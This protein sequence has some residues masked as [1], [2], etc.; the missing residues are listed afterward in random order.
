MI[1]K[2][3]AFLLSIFALLALSS[4]CVDS[5]ETTVNPNGVV[6][7]I[8]NFEVSHISWE[9]SDS[10]NHWFTRLNVPHI[11]E[12][13]IDYGAVLVYFKNRYNS[14]VLLPFSTTHQ[15]KDSV[16]FTEEIWSSYFLN[17][18]DID[19]KYNHPNNATPP[20]SMTFKVVVLKDSWYDGVYR[21]VDLNNFK[22]LEKLFDL[23]QKPMN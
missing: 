10:R 5:N 13:V 9:S 12:D 22:S 15:T 14:W 2:R 17:G 20:I 19:Y 3:F 1:V 7:Y 21:K 11:N 23:N 18:V 6:P 16:N 4:S 8:Y